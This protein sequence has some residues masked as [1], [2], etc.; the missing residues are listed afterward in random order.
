MWTKIHSQIVQGVTKEAIWQL[1]TDVNHWPSWHGDL[2][3]CKM[4]GAFEVG[5]HFKLKP[6]GA[7]PVKVTITH[8][9]EGLKFTDC[10]CFPGAKMY[11]THAIEETDNGLLLTNTLVVNGPLKW[12]WIKLVAAHIAETVPDEMNALVGLARKSNA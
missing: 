3:Y 9:D 4:N 12:L 6:K 5:N 7:F 1:W 11:D 10:T 8:I 2:D